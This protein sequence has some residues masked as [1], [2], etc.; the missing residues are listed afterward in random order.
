M[1]WFRL[2]EHLIIF[3]FAIYVFYK[4]Q[5]KLINFLAS[6]SFGVA[7]LYAIKIVVYAFTS[8]Q[9]TILSLAIQS[10]A[11]IAM[12]FMLCRFGPFK[13][14]FPMFVN[15][16]NSRM[17][18]ICS[19]TVF[20]MHI[21]F[22]FAR[23]H[24]CILWGYVVMSLIFA[25]GTLLTLG[26]WFGRRSQEIE[27][28]Y[29][30]NMTN[31]EKK[32]KSIETE[33]KS[34]KKTIE[35]LQFF[36]H[37]NC[38]RLEALEDF[39]ELVLSPH[40]RNTYRLKSGADFRAELS[41]LEDEI[42]KFRKQMARSYT[43]KKGNLPLTNISELDY[44]TERFWTLCQRKNIEFQ[45]KVNGN[46]GHMVGHFLTSSQLRTLITDMARNAIRA[47][48]SSELE[49]RRILMILGKGSQHYGLTIFDSGIP[50][51]PHVL[52]SLGKERIT[53]YGAQG[54]TGIGWVKTFEI[55]DNRRVSLIIREYKPDEPGFTKSITFVF[56]KKKEHIIETYR[57]DSFVDS[58]GITIRK[59]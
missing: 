15:K 58:K 40:R 29:M 46:I 42:T 53:T 16:R 18:T 13:N 43:L 26:A 45:L 28:G 12:S 31:L 54:G 25:S 3:V 6:V 57:P 10:F 23:L 47:V 41:I 30:V 52:V 48:E 50:F 32:I 37:S 35:E 27:K 8:A 9:Y 17:I 1:L 2:F 14:G 21:V 38:E 33:K 59:H 22:I 36:A 20:L 49:P 51:D 34:L 24:E 11:Q 7:A 19:I 56:N 5:R 4:S 44:T 39:A 55:I